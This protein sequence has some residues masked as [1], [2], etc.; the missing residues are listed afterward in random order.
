M[1]AFPNIALL[2]QSSFFHALSR[3]EIVRQVSPS[4]LALERSEE[5]SE[6]CPQRIE[7]ER[8]TGSRCHVRALFG[9]LLRNARS[10]SVLSQVRCL[11]VFVGL[12][13]L[14]PPWLLSNKLSISPSS[15]ASL[16]DVRAFL[17][18]RIR[19]DPHGNGGVCGWEEQIRGRGIRTHG[20]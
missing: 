12:C 9:L 20:L 1:K 7:I 10:L 17:G 14:S 6:K 18:E 16:T 8:I 5:A 13:C 4:L 3:P 11:S 19:A 2:Y 15:R